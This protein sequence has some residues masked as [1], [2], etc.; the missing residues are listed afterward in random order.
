MPRAW[1]WNLAR[2]ERPRTGPVENR[3]SSATPG[4]GSLPC[5]R[6]TRETSLVSG[7]RAGEIIAGKFQIERVLGE[8]GMGY[9]VAARHLQLGQMVALKFMRRDVLTPDYRA[10][11][12]R[13][14][15]NT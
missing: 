10:R 15:R 11:F 3:V 1:L 9:V 4:S 8:G 5:T 6:C 7:V 13:E 12:T 14:A 2:F